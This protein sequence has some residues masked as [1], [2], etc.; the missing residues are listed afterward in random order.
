MQQ[1]LGVIDL[2]SNTTRL[3]I[4]SYRSHHSFRLLDEVREN[5]RLAEGIGEDGR[6]KQAPMDRAVATMRLYNRL[7]QS[8]DVA[9]IIPVATSAA[10]EATNGAEF[11]ARVEREAG[12]TF[13]V[14]STEEEA[15]YGYLGV[16]NTLNLSD[17]FSI[18]IGGGSTQVAM[19]RG[20]RFI[21]SI[22]QPIGALR[23]TDRFVKSDPISPKDF[24]ALEQAA[25][26]RFADVDWL[27]Q[28]GS[29]ELAGI[30]GTIRTLADID[31]KRRNYPIGLTHAYVFTREHLAETIDLL[32]GMTVHQREDVPGLNRD[33]ADLILA[34][35]VILHTVMKRGKFSQITVSGQG[36]RE[37]LFYERFL[38]GEDPPLFADLRG[39]SIQNMARN[40][41]YEAIHA[42][43][44]RDLS[45]S[46]F[47]QLTPLHGY[48]VWERELLGYAATLH[49]IGL[50]VG[51][52][53]HH[54]HGAYLIQ[55][56]A[57]QGF[58]HREIALLALM[59][60]Y[61]RKG[62]VDT[63]ELRMLLEDDDTQRVARLAALLRLSEFLERRKSQVVQSLRVEIGADVRVLART[64]GDADIEIWD[65][66]R[67]TG[68][69]RK[70]YGREMEIMAEKR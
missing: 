70:S 26:E 58:S 50:A 65:A 46:L 42:A 1:R 40:F 13:R 44:V 53:D 2:G 29:S 57:L 9:E 63:S 30:G 16:A 54:R 12:L 36:V 66:N 34:G 32:R 49:D 55:S 47:D 10:R 7:C 25:A 27:D 41:N 8:A 23:L 43:K 48:G 22:S 31:Q 17:A 20:R 67:S 56:T 11:L 38:A 4:M 6:L 28:H 21:R 60:R 37:G 59:V 45:L 15:Y 35:A 19:I 18:D 33:R 5:V 3:I 62:D 52:Y 61:H 68:L 14:L 64:S 39:F 51:Y 69:F 24:K